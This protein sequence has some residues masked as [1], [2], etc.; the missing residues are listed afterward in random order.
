MKRKTQAAAPVSK[1]YT[2]YYTETFDKI[3]A[4]VWDKETHEFVYT[5]TNDTNLAWQ[6]CDRLNAAVTR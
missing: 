2:V 6:E 3:V 4:K 1:R 5:V